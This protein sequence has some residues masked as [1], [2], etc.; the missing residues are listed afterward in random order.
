MKSKDPFSAFGGGGSANFL[1]YTACALGGCCFCILFCVMRRKRKKAGR[2]EGLSPFEKWMQNEENKSKGVVT[3]HFVAKDHKPVNPNASKLKDLHD[4]HGTSTFQK[5]LAEKVMAPKGVAD[6]TTAGAV[7]SPKQP[8][9]EE[10]DEYA[11]YDQQDDKI[12]GT[13]ADEQPQYYQEE[14]ATSH[15][16]AEQQATGAGAWTGEQ[17]Q[18]SQF[19][20]DAGAYNSGYD[21]Q[22]PGYDEYDLSA[23]SIHNP[24]FEQQPQ[25][26]QQQVPTASGTQL[27][28]KSAVVSTASP[29]GASEARLFPSKS[30]DR[31][32]DVPGRAPIPPANIGVLGTFAKP[33]ATFNP[34]GSK[35]LKGK[36]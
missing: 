2:K 33:P 4:I 10:A 24:V 28:Q 35:K 22:P 13:W 6:R 36:K 20:H 5:T 1:W 23:E 26:Q 32:D 3:P 11:V 15:A 30:Y 7:T 17:Q 12:A 29:S 16:Y 18:H 25:L 31:Y 9:Q 21:Q 14:T 8:Q 27:A 34:L 19:F